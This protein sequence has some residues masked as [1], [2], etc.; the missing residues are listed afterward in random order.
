MSPNQFVVSSISTQ[1]V[2][3]P[4]SSYGTPG[5]LSYNASAFGADRERLYSTVDE[6]IADFP[7]LTGP[8]VLWATQIFSQADPIPEQ[9]A[10]LRGALPPTMVYTGSVYLLTAGETY[11][12]K[13]RG[14]GVTTTD[15]EIP[16]PLTDITITLAL[17]VK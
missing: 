11:V 16:L 9:V 5:L 15:L 8:E 7:S 4:R 17:Q 14:D 2:G 1:P 12:I 10:I 13:V 3:V 6:V